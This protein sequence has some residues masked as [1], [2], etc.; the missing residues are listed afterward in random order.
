MIHDKYKYNVGYGHMTTGYSAVHTLCMTDQCL[1]LCLRMFSHTLVSQG[2]DAFKLCWLA[3]VKLMA[4][5]VHAG[6]SQ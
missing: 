6:C 1:L 3:I 2:D 5:Y 4:A